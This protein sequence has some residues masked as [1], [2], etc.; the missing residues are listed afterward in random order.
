MKKLF[1]ILVA[2]IFSAGFVFAQNTETTTQTGNNNDADIIQTG[3][4]QDADVSQTGNTNKTDINQ[5]ND[6]GIV[7]TAKV[8]QTGSNNDSKIDMDQL[9]YSTNTP[10]SAIIEQIGNWNVSYQRTYSPGYSSGVDVYGIQTGN[11]NDLYQRILGGYTDRF[12]AFQT[13]NNNDATQRMTG[14]TNSKGLITQDGNNNTAY[15]DLSG[16]NNGYYL[17]PSGGPITVDQNGS[18]NTADQ[19]FVSTGGWTNGNSGFVTQTGNSNYARQDVTGWAVDVQSEVIGNNNDTRQYV[20]SLGDE[21]FILAIG[22]RNIVKT[23]QQGDYNYSDIKLNSA[24]IGKA[25][26]NKVDVKQVGDYNHFELGIVRG[27]IGGDNNNVDIDHDGNGHFNRVKIDGSNNKIKIN[28]KGN[29][30]GSQYDGNRGDWNFKNGAPVWTAT[31]DNNDFVLTQDGIRNYATGFVAGDNND[32][33]LT[34]TGNNNLI[35]TSWYTQDGVAMTGNN[36]FVQ[37]RQLS[38]GNSSMNTITG[39]GNNIN[40]LQQ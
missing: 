22:D 32:I 7:A 14:G 26:D 34:Q 25:N 4:N 5:F 23:D 27:D 8:T 19:D 12:D 18:W 37:I 35:G 9:G 28:A 1:V 33:R 24:G 10:S 40:V 39:N 20:G 6:N 31:S 11:N 21:S 3:S 2:V 15:Q 30:G 17:A 13:G 29:Y 36:N 16:A 38:D